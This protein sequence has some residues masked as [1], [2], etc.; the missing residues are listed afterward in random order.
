M[1]LL[2]LQSDNKTY[3]QA[4][5]RD[6]PYPPL[7]VCFS[8]LQSSSCLKNSDRSLKRA[9]Q[10]Q[11]KHGRNKRNAKSIFVTRS[12]HGIAVLNGKILFVALTC[13]VA[14]AALRRGWRVSERI[15]YER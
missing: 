1:V 6:V 8:Y 5:S 10:Y 13:A 14:N 4:N 15:C 7:G 11:S 2:V 12:K 9:K 3:Q